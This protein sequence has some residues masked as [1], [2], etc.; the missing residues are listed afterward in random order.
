MKTV[1]GS[2]GP[3]GKYIF[4]KYKRMPAVMGRVIQTSVWIIGG[5]PAGLAFREG[6]N[7]TKFA[8]AN[9]YLLHLVKKENKE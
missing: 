3:A 4:Q 2:Q 6:K 9:P 8:D 5:V 1:N 7:A